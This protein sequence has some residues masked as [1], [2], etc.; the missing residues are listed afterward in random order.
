MF[1]AFHGD[2]WP[3]HVAEDLQFRP[4]ETLTRAGGGADRAMVFEQ[5]ERRAIR[6][7]FRHVAFA[8]AKFC[9][10]RD[11]CAQR[12]CVG[13]RRGIST[14]RFR[15]AGAYQPLQGGLAERR[16]HRLDQ[17]HGEFRMGV[18]EA[19]VGRRRQ[20]PEACRP[21]DAVLLGL[22]LDQPIVR[23]LDELLARRLRRGAKHRRDVRGTQ[24]TAPLDQPKDAVAG[25]DIQAHTWRLAPAPLLM[26]VF[27]WKTFCHCER[28]EAISVE[29]RCYDRDCCGPAGLAMTVL[30]ALLCLR[31]PEAQGRT[32]RI[33]DDRK[34][35]LVRDVHHVLHDGRTE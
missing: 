34:R 25:T 27:S 28:G 17:A 33:D 14:S 5:Q 19:A 7:P 1:D 35:S 9:Q 23:K 24:R 8:R 15:L 16:S 31:L 32:G 22:R 10:L 30:K 3:E 4:A 11:P 29:W 18:G 6:A 2:A 12:R 21:A 20:M 26:Q 13:Q